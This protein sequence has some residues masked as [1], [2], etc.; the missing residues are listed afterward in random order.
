MVNGRWFF[1]FNLGGRQALEMATGEVSEDIN[2]FHFINVERLY[3]IF[4][5]RARCLKFASSV[6]IK[7]NIVP[8]VARQVTEPYIVG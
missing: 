7:T 4:D 5:L 2:R 8:F 1:Q 3:S 6:I